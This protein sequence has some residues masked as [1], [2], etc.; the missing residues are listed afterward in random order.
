M[1]FNV[2]R[3]IKVVNCQITSLYTKSKIILKQKLYLM[4][5]NNSVGLNS[6]KGNIQ[7]HSLIEL[8]LLYS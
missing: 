2:L 1:L 8:L 4:R 7:N 3:K 5:E 6:F